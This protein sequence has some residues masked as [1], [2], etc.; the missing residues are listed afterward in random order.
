MCAI[1]GFFDY[2]K[3]ISANKLKKLINA[4]AVNAEVRGTDAT[5]ISYVKNSK[6]IRNCNIGR[7]KE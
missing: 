2:G 6:I 4:L 3:K 1:F 7:N 5:G